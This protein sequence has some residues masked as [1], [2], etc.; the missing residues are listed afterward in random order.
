MLTNNHRT[1]LPGNYYQL[2]HFSKMSLV[3]KRV[4]LP[5]MSFEAKFPEH[6][7][8]KS[9]FKFVSFPSYG[10]NFRFHRSRYNNTTGTIDNIFR[11]WT[12]M[13]NTPKTL[14]CGIE[15]IDFDMS[16]CQ[17]FKIIY[18]QFLGLTSLPTS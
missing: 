1:M 13:A 18:H 15:I 16:D 6:L 11:Y 2:F 8:V 4:L 10:V 14:N 7:P 17:E 3:N 9:M 12:R 5:E